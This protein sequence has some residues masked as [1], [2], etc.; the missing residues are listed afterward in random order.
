MRLVEKKFKLNVW[1]VYGNS[2]RVIGIWVIRY[3][4]HQKLNG[5]LDIWDL[6]HQD[7]DHQYIKTAQIWLLNAVFGLVRDG[8][9]N[10]QRIR[11]SAAVDV[12]STSGNNNTI[13][14][15]KDDE[16]LERKRTVLET[17]GYAIGKTI[18]NGSYATVKIADSYRHKS[19]VAIKIISKFQAP[20]DYLIK[21][22]PREIEVVKGLKH[23]NLIRFL[24]AIETTHRVYIIMEYAQ[25]GSLLDTIRRDIF[26]DENRSRKWFKQL[27][28]AVDYCHTRGVVHRD[29]KCENL[30]MDQHLNI[31]LSD[32]GFARGHMNKTD[33]T[34]IL[35]ETFCGSYAYASPEILR[36]IPYQ[37]QMSDIWSLGIVLYAMVYGRLPFDDKN[38]GQLIKQVQSQVKFPKE[39][40]VSYS[41]R[42]LIR[43]ILVPQQS[44]IKIETIKADDW[45]INDATVIE[46]KFD[47]NKILN[48]L[49]AE[50]I[51]QKPQE[52]DHEKLMDQM[53]LLDKQL[54]RNKIER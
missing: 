27:L 14:F 19:P 39:P 36:G 53:V 47:H 15:E 23:P 45:L 20:S 26:I 18:G 7:G 28:D 25:N 38:Y 40:K 31:K 24:Q 16:K 17:H 37:P 35:S 3:L 41:C 5:N 22:L 34:T 49:P 8:G 6:N 4:Y 43:R 2:I 52:N 51:V 30:L 21:F 29:I 42:S 32:F 11:E 50:A 1:L 9:H 54:H 13:S 10:R 12:P 33:G 44:R 48:I 46:E